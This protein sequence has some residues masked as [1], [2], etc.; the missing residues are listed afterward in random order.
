MI[1]FTKIVEQNLSFR[2]Y[3]GGN[4]IKK[5]VLFNGEPYMLKIEHRDKKKN[6][7]KNSVLSEY[8][9][10]KIYSIL[11]FNTQEV[12]LGTIIDNGKKNYVLLVKI[13]RKKMSIYMNL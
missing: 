11:G 9:S 13:L 5:G 12:V 1:D 8:V 10:C 3:G 7:Y 2:A 6:E 4:G